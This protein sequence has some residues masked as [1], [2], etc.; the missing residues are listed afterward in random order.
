MSSDEEDDGTE[1]NECL[2]RDLA[3]LAVRINIGKHGRRTAPLSDPITAV[4]HLDPYADR[5]IMSKKEAGP[6]RFAERLREEHFDADGVPTLVRWQNQWYGFCDGSYRHL[7]DETIVALL[8]RFLDQFELVRKDDDGHDRFDRLRVTPHLVGSVR[9][10]LITDGLFPRIGPAQDPP[11]WLRNPPPWHPLATLA[12]PNGVVHLV[13]GELRP[14]SPDLFNTC[15]VPVRFDAT[16][17]APERWLRFLD[18]VFGGDVSS[19][20]TLQMMMGYLLTPDTSQ[21][22]AFLL[23]GPRRSG[24][25]TIARVIQDLVGSDNT[26]APTLS[27]LQERFGLSALLGKS[28]AIIGDARL[29]A[30]PDQAT[31]AEVFLRITGQDA[32]N[33]DRKGLPIVQVKSSVRFVL[34]AN[35]V[36]RLVDESGAFASRFLILRMLAT[37]EG[38]EDVTL[39]DHLREELPGILTWAIEG[40]R[41]LRRVGRF[42]Q[43]EAA[44]ADLESMRDISSPHTTFLEECCVFD[45]GAEVDLDAL[46]ERWRA[47]CHRVGR[48]HPG[49]KHVFSRDVRSAIPVPRVVNRRRPDGGRRYCFVGLM[50]R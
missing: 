22:K 49:P 43:P 8:W 34:L 38:R 5:F 11:L 29:T 23:V 26:A 15:A 2:S 28:V 40:W 18:E 36:P 7:P 9:S 24:K 33:V 25:G 10:A 1:S 3:A 37:F 44:R 45:E 20:E 13:D 14:P 4:P 21:Q 16:A 12:C 31:I 46:Y 48:D 6:L 32:L 50:L 39:Q 17:P 19:I 42:A 41:R 47:W 27:G 30:R 35:A